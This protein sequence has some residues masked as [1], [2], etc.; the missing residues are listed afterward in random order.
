M[1][2]YLRYRR[3]PRD[4][5]ESAAGRMEQL[6]DVGPS[7]PVASGLKDYA[8]SDLPGAGQRVRPTRGARSH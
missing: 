4:S 7:D 5:Q 2:I 3:H 6:V 1:L 8:P